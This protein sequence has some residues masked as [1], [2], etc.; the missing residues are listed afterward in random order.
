MNS[1]ASLSSLPNGLALVTLTSNFGT[2]LLYGLTNIVAS[3]PSRERHEFHGL[4]H[5]VV[6]VFGAV[7]N[8]ACLAFYI[9]GPMEGLGSVKEPLMAVGL[10]R[11]GESTAR[12]T[13]CVIP[14]SGAKR[15]FW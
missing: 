7:A 8:F 6:P 10:P 4:K 1:N 3:W 11:F 12:F 15:R 14:R 9:I 2:F 13:S 5:M